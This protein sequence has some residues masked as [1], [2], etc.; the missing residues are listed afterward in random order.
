MDRQ[1][2]VDAV[3]LKYRIRID[4]DDPAFILVDLNRLA[5][6]KSIEGIDSKLEPAIQRLETRLDARFA[7]Q[8]KKTE[9]FADAS[10]ARFKSEVE[11]LV[12]SSWQ[13]SSVQAIEP[14]E[15][16]H[17]EAEPTNRLSKSLVITLLIGLLF[18][19][20]IATGMRGFQ[21]TPEQAET[22]AAEELARL[23]QAKQLAECKAPGWVERSGYCY[24]TAVEGKVTGWRIR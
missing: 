9:V 2:L 19:F 18:G 17:A 6:E 13:G 24:A 7:E 5:L 8:V 21:H 4:K 10:L 16:A 12:R 20:G 23:G 22:V 14:P 15:K 11:R 3:Y 1:A